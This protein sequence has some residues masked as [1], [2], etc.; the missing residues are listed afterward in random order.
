MIIYE[1]ENG[2]GLGPSGVFNLRMLSRPFALLM[3]LD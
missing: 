1:V 3:T 2:K